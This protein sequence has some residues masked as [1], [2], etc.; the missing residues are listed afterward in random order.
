MRGMSAFVF[1]AFAACAVAPVRAAEPET[2]VAA[3]PKA[4]ELAKLLGP[5]KLMPRLGMP[6]DFERKQLLSS[7]YN[8]TLVWKGVP[9]NE[10]DARCSKVA[11]EISGHALADR[12]AHEKRMTEQLYAL[13]FQRTLT[14]EAMDSA[15]AF[16]K[17]EN[18]RRFSISTSSFWNDQE[19]LTLLKPG[20]PL[21]QE[22]QAWRMT[23]YLEE[24]YDRTKNLPRSDRKAPPPPMA[25]K[26]ATSKAPEGQ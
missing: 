3:G 7:M 14:D 9:C 22:W 10:K 13:H 20:T 5:Q 2:I 4:L 1:V 6:S 11:E 12:Q 25:S 16:L 17:T 21:F 24:F 15:I 19:V 18:G 26:P 23:P 8:T